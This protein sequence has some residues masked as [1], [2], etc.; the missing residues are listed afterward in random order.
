MRRVKYKIYPSLLDA[1]SWYLQSDSD[2]REQELIDK[3]NR[4][5]FESEKADRGTA[6][7]EIVDC[8]IERRKSDIMQIE[9]V[10]GVSV[11]GF[12]DP[13]DGKAEGDV[14]PSNEVVALKAIYN[15]REFS[16]PIKTCKEFAA[17]YKGAIT[18]QRVEAILKTRFGDVL[19]YGVI[20]ELMPLSVHDIKTTSSYTPFKFRGHSQH[21]VYPYCLIQN[22][23]DIRRFEYNVLEFNSKGEPVD[24][25]TEVYVFEPVR[26]T[27]QLTS[28]VEDFIEFLESKRELIT[29]RKVFAL[30]NEKRRK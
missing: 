10:N 6:F 5:P 17:Y 13:C 24:T 2:N 3:I 16:F 11:T 28:M 21:L 29:D 14:E 23:N 9:R 30:D 19:V 18:Q 15:G 1:Y 25:H 4:V 26:D 27:Q 8:I 20:D 22:G 7:N 12:V